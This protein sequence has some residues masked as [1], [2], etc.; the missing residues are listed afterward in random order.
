MSGSPL[1]R[2]AL[3]TLLPAF[4]GHRPPEWAVRL[5]EEG[6]GGYT[7]F[8]YNIRDAA[9][10]LELTTRLRDARPDVVIATDE[11]GGDV[12]RL[13]YADGSP[14]P[15]NAAL[16]VVDDVALTEAVYRAIGARL[17][18]VGI[19]LD[20]APAV[21]V[22]SA[23]DNPAIGTRSFGADPAR[24]AA[25]AAAA[26]AGLQ[27]AGVAACA[28]H[29]PGHGATVTDSHLDLPLVA[30]PLSVLRQRELPPFAAAIAAGARSVMTAHIRVPE[31]TGSAPATFSRRTLRELLRE[32]LGFAGAVVSD[33][34]EMR[35]ASAAIGIPE[36][37]V[38][39][40]A[41]GN[42]LLCFGGE[43]AKSP[44]AEAVVEKTVAAIVAAVGEGRLTESDLV[45][46]AERNRL[47]GA[48][49]VAA[50]DLDDSLGLTAA[51]RA[52]R[53]SGVLPA[54]LADAVVVQLMPPATAAVGEVPWGLAPVLPG[55][56]AVA[57]TWS[58]ADLVALAGDRPL[59]VACRDTHRHPWARALVEAAAATHPGVVLVEMGWPAA[60]RPTGAAYV[61]TYGAAP[62]NAR[63]AAESLGL[64]ATTP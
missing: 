14:Y 47:L 51:R 52:V 9:Q 20:M 45:A 33:A 41:A 42:D 21:D 8:G 18:S 25:H 49:P 28:K 7:L 60:W 17:A 53:V 30:A 4:P 11:E 43:L 44:D 61:A 58:A 54:G 39:A 3:A 5:V 32:E 26:V 13:H 50:G 63:A 31:L 12:T 55:V 62:V 38:R 23:D 22:N 15:G 6:L 40:L 10:V 29:F 34:L 27:A 1:R 46:S 57:D 59:V 36:A 35:G 56:V 64:S 16:G 19:T 37:A 48:P 2:L 24:V